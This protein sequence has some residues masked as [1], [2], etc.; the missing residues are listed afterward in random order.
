MKD[1][2]ALL[3]NKRL[4]S[5]FRID[6]EALRTLAHAFLVVPDLIGI[7]AFDLGRFMTLPHRSP[8]LASESFARKQELTIF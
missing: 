1:F 5:T 8:T 4:R 7:E 3:L 2:E 6:V